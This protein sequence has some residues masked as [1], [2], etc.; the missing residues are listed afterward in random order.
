MSCISFAMLYSAAEGNF[1]PWAIKQILRFMMLFPLMILIAITDIRIWY[2]SAYIIFG[3]T[4]VGLVMTEFFGVTAMGATRWI[5]MGPFNIQPSEIVKISLVLALAR[6]FHRLNASNIGNLLYLL[7]PLMMIITPFF[8]VVR[9][10]DLGTSLIILMIG[11]TILFVT[12]VRWWKFAIV[13]V[14]A[15]AAIPIIWQHLHDYQ[16]ARIFA[17][18]NPEND[19]LGNG[20][21]ILQSIIAVGSGGLMGKGFLHG[22]QSQ[23]SFLP[24]KQT[25]FIFTMLAEEFGF[26]GGM[27]VIILYAIIIGYGFI[28][29]LSCRNHY[30]RLLAIGV[31]SMFFFHIFINIAMV[32]GLIPVV[33]AP[34]PLLSYGGTIMMT[35]LMGFGFLLNAH[36]YSNEIF[37]E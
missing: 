24:E 12:G 14:G 34:L 4:I 7:V 27:G 1:Q 29:A 25:D 6:Y 8:F 36:L 11:G 9:Q 37:D 16:K 18:I 13:G 30:S 23:L 5:R 33:G 2:H 32:M 28:I 19:P 10:P 21:N 3:L 17:F 22:T 15:I 31:T 26:V 35:S 20:Y